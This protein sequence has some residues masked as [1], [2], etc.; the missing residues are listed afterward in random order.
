MWFI[1]RGE[2]N[3]YLTLIDKIAEKKLIDDMY[4]QYLAQFKQKPWT[5]EQVEENLMFLRENH[6][7]VYKT[8][9]KKHM[10]D[11]NE[12]LHLLNYKQSHENVNPV[13]RFD[14]I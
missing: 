13:L 3:V 9:Q 14:R 1:L 4:E 12:F 2:I 11:N 6:P 5:N 7:E 8:L 10:L